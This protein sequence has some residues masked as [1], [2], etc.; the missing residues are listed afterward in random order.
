MSNEDLEKQNLEL[1]I[2]NKKLSFNLETLK[3]QCLGLAVQ[4]DSIS[5]RCSLPEIGFKE[6]HGDQLTRIAR[7]L[8]DIDK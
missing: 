1:R 7:E 3:L 4:I 5:K 2:A 8:K 6:E